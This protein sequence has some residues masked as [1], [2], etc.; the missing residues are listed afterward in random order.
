[1]R[2]SPNY[3]DKTSKNRIIW[4]T[5]PI[6]VVPLRQ[7]S[8][9]Y[10]AP[11]SKKWWF[12]YIFFQEKYGNKLAIRNREAFFGCLW[13]SLIPKNWQFPPAVEWSQRM[14]GNHKFHLW[15]NLTSCLT[16]SNN[17]KLAKNNG[18]ISGKNYRKAPWSS[19]ENR[20]FPVSIFP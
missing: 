20:R 14:L 16:N 2:E 12:I 13:E 9:L 8:P 10:P 18:L 11:R 19:W 4:W 5:W 15:R 3:G 6:C 7:L 17:M 1:M